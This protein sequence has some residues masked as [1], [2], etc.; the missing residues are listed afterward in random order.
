MK[1]IVKKNKAIFFGLFIVNLI[2]AFLAYFILPDKFFSDTKIIILDIG[3]EIGF[4]GSYPLSILFYKVTL[5]RYLP[6]PIIALIQYPVLIYILYKIG[7]PKDFHILTVKNILVYLAFFMLAIFVSMPSKEFITFIYISLITFVL[8]NPTKSARHR[9]LLALFLVVLFGLFFRIYYV[10]IPVIA[11]G[12]YCVTFIKFKNKTVTTIFY[13]VLISIF[14]SLS[15]GV[16][17]GEYISETTREEL[18]LERK[19]A[20]DA[21]SMI[22]SPVATDTWYGEIIGVVNGFIAVNIPVV[23]GLKHIL[24]PQIIAFIVWQLFLFYILLK[25]FS[26]CINDR[27]E[28]QIQLWSLLIIL[29]YFIT[30]GL[31]EPDLGSAIRHKMGFFPLIYFVLYYENF[32]RKL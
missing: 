18:N 10:F 14:I 22:V 8:N 20:H 16:L 31:F 12:M 3:N 29:S 13:G 11:L 2:I 15:V 6:F 25:R 21:N 19:N 9:I 28:N 24:S 27:K 30:Q 17:T 32:R 7:I 26:W 4:V 5:L 23:E 1:F